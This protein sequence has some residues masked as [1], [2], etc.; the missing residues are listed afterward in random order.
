MADFDASTPSSARIYDALLGGKDN[1]AVDREVAARLQAAAPLAVQVAKENRQFLSR[2]VTWVAREGV[3]Q[4]IDLGCGMPTSPATHESARSVIPAAR[5]AYVDNDAVVI[6]RLRALTAKGDPAITVVDG[7]LRDPAAILA[8]V[9][10][11]IDLSQPACLVMG[12]LLHFFPAGAARDL[13]AAYT[14]ALAPGSYVVLSAGRADSDDGFG[15]YSK[16]G[17]TVY[18]HTDAEF[19]GFFG[20]LEL[21]DPG[22]ADSREWRPGWEEQVRLPWRQG[23]ALAGVARVSGEPG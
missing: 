3:S 13:A 21:T 8:A 1:F 11:G 12:F 6:A 9:A 7:D 16:A 5:V 19:A 14:A 15:A 18:N 22:I 10:A 2:A 23:G 20:A 17:P 4:F